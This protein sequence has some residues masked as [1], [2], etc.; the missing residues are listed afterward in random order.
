MHYNFWCS[1]A[2]VGWLLSAAQ[3]VWCLWDPW[4]T[5]Q[6]WVTK[7]LTDAGN[8]LKYGAGELWI[9]VILVTHDHHEGHVT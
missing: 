4:C 5:K 8:V 9:A 6:D 3:C 1:L 7:H 2:L